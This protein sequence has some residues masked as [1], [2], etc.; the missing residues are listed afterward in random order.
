MI[1]EHKAPTSKK[2]DQKVVFISIRPPHPHVFWRW[3][4]DANIHTL[5]VCLFLE[6]GPLLCLK[7]VQEHDSFD[8]TYSL[9]HL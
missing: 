7:V 5:F 3:L 1:Y 2:I 6:H 8:S 4:G 9:F